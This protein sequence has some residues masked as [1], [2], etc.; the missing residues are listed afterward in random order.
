[1][2]HLLAGLY[3]DTKNYADAEPL[4]AGLAAA[5]PRDTGLVDERARALI[6]LRK[7]AEA[8]QI[9]APL[10]AQPKVFPTPGDLG[11]AAGDLAFAASENNDPRAALQALEVR[12]TVLPPSAPVLFL[13]AISYDKLHQNKLAIEAYKRFL[14][15]S[16]GSNPEEE[17]SARHRLIALEHVR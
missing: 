12:A 2:G 10:V 7:F 3:L 1:M 5:N 13:T 6:Q 11:N 16:K 4:L 17:F 8:Q 15:A 14:E 9:L